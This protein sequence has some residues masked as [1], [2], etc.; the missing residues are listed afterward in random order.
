MDKQNT[1]TFLLL[2]LAH[3]QYVSKTF[4]VRCHQDVCKMFMI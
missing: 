4:S 3:L 2:L 1:K